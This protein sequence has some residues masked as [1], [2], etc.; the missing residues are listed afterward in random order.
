MNQRFISQRGVMLCNRAGWLVSYL[1][2][3]D[4]LLINLFKKR[5]FLFLNFSD[6]SM[7]S[8][9]IDFFKRNTATKKRTSFFRN[10]RLYFYISDSIVLSEEVFLFLKEKVCL[11]PFII[12]FF[13]R[14]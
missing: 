7:D 4:V 8:S 2:H 10:N 12:N 9:Q 13:K 1:L 5:G 14:G 11:G 6:S 3:N